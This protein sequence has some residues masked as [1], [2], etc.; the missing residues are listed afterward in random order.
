MHD[1]LVCIPI[2]ILQHLYVVL[3]AESE[4]DLQV[5]L[6][7]L[8]SWYNEW[9]LQVNSPKITIHFRQVNQP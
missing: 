4:D 6:K 9:S 5:V 1:L 7:L 2:E 3:C 8:N